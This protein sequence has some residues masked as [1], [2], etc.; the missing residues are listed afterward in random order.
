MSIL[1]KF[2]IATLCLLSS[3]ISNNYEVKGDNNGGFTSTPHWILFRLDHNTKVE[4][5]GKYLDEL[6]IG[7]W[8]YNV[9]KDHKFSLEWERIERNDLVL[10]IPISWKIDTSSRYDLFANLPFG[11]SFFFVNI[12]DTAILEFSTPLRHLEGLYNFSLSNSDSKLVKAE[13]GIIDYQDNNQAIT[14]EFDYMWNDSLWHALGFI[15]TIEDKLADVEIRNLSVGQFSE[16]ENKFIF[17][18]IINDLKFSG[19]RVIQ[20]LDNVSNIKEIKFE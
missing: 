8:E 11:N 10:S 14:Y 16:L 17:T 6:T 1:L 19:V 13:A 3:C 15:T 2:S 7:K 12:R 18:N 20:T 5:K 4:G 9:N